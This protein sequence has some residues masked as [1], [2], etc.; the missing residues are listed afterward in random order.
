MKRLQYRILL[1]NEP[2]GVY[3]VIVPALSG[4]I[5]YGKIVGEAIA[6]AKEAIEVYVE[7]LREKGEKIPTGEGLLGNTLTVEVDA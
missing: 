3:T 2:E 1:R 5:T 7:D 6:R 4:C